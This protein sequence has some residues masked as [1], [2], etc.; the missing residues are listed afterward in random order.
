MSDFNLRQSTDYRI[1]ELTLVTK[2]GKIDIRQMFEEINI[3]ESM[4]TPC[5]SGDIIISDAIGLSSQ[6]LIDG[7]ELL[8]IDID[9][10]AGFGNM[11]RAF[12]IYQQ[13][14]RKNKNQTSEIYVLKFASEE[15]VLSEQQTL[16]E[17]YKGT[18]TD[19]VKKILVNKLK[20]SGNN[21]KE[22]NFEK[23]VGAIDVII[24]MLKPFDA[25]NWCSKRA[26]DSKGQ[27]TFLFF[28]NDGGY[29]FTTLSKIMQQEPI[30]SVNFDVKNLS[31]E[32]GDQNLKAELLGARAMEV[33]S[34]FDF[35]KNTQAGVFAGTYVGID[36]LT[37]QIIPEKKTF[38]TSYGSTS[39]ANRNPNLPI[40]TNKL[41]KTNSQM[42]QSR[43]VYHLT[44]GSRNQSQWIKNG[45]PG[46]LT[47]DDVPQKYTYARK[48]IFQ[49]FTAQRLKIALPGNF[50]ISPGKTINLDVPKRS[51]NTRGADNSDVTLKGKYA[52]LSTRHIIKY[53]MFETIAEVVTD[54]SAKPIVAANRELTQILGSY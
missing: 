24:P 44:T 30:F 42:D 6:L 17:C 26:I 45:E 12:R 51:F 34:Q 41:N 18:Y 33:I 39:H 8:L 27:P 29:N 10:G 43:I 53:K 32:N 3:Y 23:S 40:D 38:N 25:I 28:E 19:I 16:S 21:F 2:G 49:N 37:R 20:V 54:S 5:I 14:D 47:T 13:S 11:K 50:L 46:S 36:P 35:I 9:K 52:I 4:L 1:N 15:I 7:S 48:A 22:R 31:D